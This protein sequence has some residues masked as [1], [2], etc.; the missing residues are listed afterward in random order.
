MKYP[1]TCILALLFAGAIHGQATLSFHAGLGYHFSQQIGKV[2]FYENPPTYR[3]RLGVAAGA[4]LNMPLKKRGLYQLGLLYQDKATD[5]RTAPISDYGL[6]GSLRIHYLGLHQNALYRFWGNKQRGL[7]AGAGLYGAV[8]LGGQFEEDVISM[9]GNTHREGGIRFGS[10]TDALFRRFDA[11]GNLLVM[12]QC[13]KWQA[14]LQLSHSF[15]AYNKPEK[16]RFTSLSL[17]LGYS[18]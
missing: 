5:Y 16:V 12:G 7:Y 18:L 3:P 11:G 6:Q 14:T 15:V 2:L 13:K 1:F 17:M 9:L 10:G 4:N 8:A